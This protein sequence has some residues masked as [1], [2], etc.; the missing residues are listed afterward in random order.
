MFALDNRQCGRSYVREKL[1]RDMSNESAWNFLT[2][3]VCVCVCV[4]VFGAR[5]TAI[6]RPQADAQER[7]SGVARV[8][9]R[10]S[11]TRGSRRDV[12][13]GHA[14]RSAQQICRQII[15][16]APMV[17]ARAS[18]WRAVGVWLAVR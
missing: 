8:C 3:C 9:D 6:N 15:A 10:G 11:R 18:G 2:G 13:L 14:R 7:L 12:S 17:G 16:D 1:S 4:C 5:Q